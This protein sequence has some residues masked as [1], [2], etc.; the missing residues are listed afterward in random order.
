MSFSHL[1]FHDVFKGQTR[2][3][4]FRE[5]LMFPGVLCL[6]HENPLIINWHKLHVLLLA[7]GDA[8]DLSYIA[9]MNI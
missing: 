3:N 2:K 6:L 1:P 5:F 4:N 9:N 8:K 7:F